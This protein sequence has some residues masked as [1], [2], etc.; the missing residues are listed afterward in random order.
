MKTEIRSA[1]TLI[2][3]MI[4]LGLLGALLAVA[5][6]LLGTFRDAEI[7]GWKLAHRTQTIRSARAWLEDDIQH[8][9]IADGKMNSKDSGFAKPTKSPK[10]SKNARAPQSTSTIHFTG[11]AMGFSATIAPSINPIPFLENLMSDSIQ[12][13]RESSVTE[14]TLYEPPIV[15]GSSSDITSSSLWPAETVEIE[16]QLTSIASDSGSLTSSLVGISD[17]IPFALIRREMIDS[18]TNSVA[19]N[20]SERVLTA[21]DLYRQSDQETLETSQPIRELRLE[22]LLKA[23]F[24]YFDGSSWKSDWNSQQK[25]GLPRAIAL[26]FDFPA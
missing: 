20:L 25:G 8:L 15:N 17:Q 24:R 16:Y 18:N 5:W 6:S 21:Q 26:G 1:F 4:A 7:R 23:Q 22:G 3:L 19:V 14:S 9:A 13:D 11:N 2:E 12:V 10:S